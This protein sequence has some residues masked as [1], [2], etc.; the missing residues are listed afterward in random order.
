MYGGLS[1]GTVEIVFGRCSLTS[2]G[3]IEHTGVI[4]EDYQTEITIMAPVKGTMQIEAG[5]ES[6]S[7]C[8]SHT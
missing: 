6:R 1:Q 8:H 7:C 5:E 3:F 4:D 2:Q